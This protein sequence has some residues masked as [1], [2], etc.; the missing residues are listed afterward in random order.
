MNIAS[1]VIVIMIVVVPFFVCTVRA[2]NAGFVVAS[3]VNDDLVVVVFHF[4]TLAL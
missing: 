3:A 1:T 2:R 4:K